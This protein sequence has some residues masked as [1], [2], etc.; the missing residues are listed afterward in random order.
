MNQIEPNLAGIVLG[1]RR[2]RFVQI[3]L[4]LL[5]GEHKG[6]IELISLGLWVL[7]PWTFI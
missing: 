3:K 5:E 4:I 1:N 6:G 2:F 7:I